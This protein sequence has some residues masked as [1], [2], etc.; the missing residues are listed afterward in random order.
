MYILKNVKVPEGYKYS[1][2]CTYLANEIRENRNKDENMD[3]LFRLT[4]PK[5]ISDVA[6]YMNLMPL[7]DLEGYLPLAFM[8]TVMNFDPTLST[9]SFMGY[10]RKVLRGDIINGYYGKYKYT[11]EKRDLKRRVDGTTTSINTPVIDT[12]GTD[13]GTYEDLLE[14]C[15]DIDKELLNAD[16][17]DDIMTAIDKV[18]DRNRKG[19]NASIVSRPKVMFTDYIMSIINDEK[20]SMASIAE[21]HGVAKSTFSTVV[22]KYRGDFRR[23]LYNLGYDL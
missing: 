13:C 12:D 20:V 22:Y 8:K 10:Y 15:F 16:F 17:I 19:A 11:P 9:V 2:Y 5:A 6:R 23:E 21:K 14:D 3:I 4:Y 7:E 18:F 1:E